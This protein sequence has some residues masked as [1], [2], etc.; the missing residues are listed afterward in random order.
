[1]SLVQKIFGN[2]APTIKPRSG[3]TLYLFR[4][5]EAQNNKDEII[6]GDSPL[7]RQ[8]KRHATEVGHAL[9]NLEFEAIH[10]STLR[11]N[12]DTAKRVGRS[13]RGTRIIATAL[14]DEIDAG[15]FHDVPEAVF[16]Q[17]YRNLAV[18]RDNDKYHWKYPNGESYQQMEERIAE[19]LEEIRDTQGSVAVTGHRAVNRLILAQLL[20]IDRDLAPHLYMPHDAIFEVALD[21]RKNKA[22]H[23]RFGKR[24][25][26]YEVQDQY[27]TEDGDGIISRVNDRLK[28][29]H[30]TFGASSFALGFGLVNPDPGLAMARYKG[31]IAELQ[32]RNSRQ[33][34]GKALDDLYT[35]KKENGRLVYRVLFGG[36]RKPF[37]V[38]DQPVFETVNDF[39][40]NLVPQPQRVQG[41]QVHFIPDPEGGYQVL[42]RG[43]EFNRVQPGASVVKERLLVEYM[44][45]SSARTQLQMGEER[46]AQTTDKAQALKE[47]ELLRENLVPKIDGESP[48][49]LAWTFCEHMKSN[50]HEI[51]GYDALFNNQKEK[52]DFKHDIATMCETIKKLHRTLDPILEMAEEQTREKENVHES[53]DN[54]IR[55]YRVNEDGTETEITS[56]RINLSTYYMLEQNLIIDLSRTILA[57]YDLNLTS[58]TVPLFTQQ[59]YEENLER[60]I[61]GQPR[62]V[63]EEVEQRAEKT[64]QL[65]SH[66]LAAA[67]AK[68]Y[69]HLVTEGVEVIY[70]ADRGARPF[71]KAFEAY[72]EKLKVTKP[73]M[74]KIQTR[75]FKFT[76]TPKTVKYLKEHDEEC[77][78]LLAEEGQQAAEAYA[79]DFMKKAF[80]DF[81]PEEDSGKRIRVLDDWIR[82]GTTRDATVELL[83]HVG[84]DAIPGH[85]IPIVR[86][87]TDTSP[88]AMLNMRQASELM[89]TCA[90]AP[91]QPSK[92]G[93]PW[94]YE[95]VTQ[96]FQKEGI[97]STLKELTQTS[98][99]DHLTYRNVLKWHD[100]SVEIGVQYGIDLKVAD[101]SQAFVIQEELTTPENYAKLEAYLQQ[102]TKEGVVDTDALIGLIANNYIVTR[103]GGEQQ[104]KEM[105]RKSIPSHCVDT[106]Q[107][108]RELAEV[109]TDQFYTVIIE[110]VSDMFDKHGR[111]GLLTLFDK[112]YS[113]I[114][115]T[116]M[117][118]TTPAK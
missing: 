33:S 118:G 94:T 71:G 97:R 41:K 114:S 117:D 48:H 24:H 69:E 36:A 88:Y 25:K 102:T 98:E 12:Q 76:S 77:K 8:G 62:A 99:N 70:F 40:K 79:L 112:T 46:L 74:E 81:F 51:D 47:L 23:F 75:Y 43:E 57:K 93:L 11:R 108:A 80:E 31:E 95:G 68:L 35:T 19:F 53:S 92:Q 85:V 7:T 83:Q 110:S 89:I 21:T 27:E 39:L 32:L 91:K 90:P 14:L 29:A 42:S 78:R 2:R 106:T 58:P 100:T 1:M 17:Q 20:D 82:T 38:P 15:D 101:T 59:G 64:P 104:D 65:D 105:L 37:H 9:S 52:E 66:Y 113:A 109:I 84:V 4:H 103:R 3:P 55:I 116:S 34:R 10:C 5:G 111:D 67:A 61:H 22:H 13:H 18:A 16:Q 6:G 115:P 26:G 73:N 28:T 60:L 56:L 63:E 107:G 45:W 96:R 49:T 87:P 50:I 54:N 72:M 44:R 86:T 30:Y